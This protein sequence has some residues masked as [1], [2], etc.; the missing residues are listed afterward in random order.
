MNQK[1][2]SDL[3]KIKTELIDQSHF[4][5]DDTDKLFHN[6]YKVTVSYNG[7]KTSF[8]FYDSAHNTDM[9]IEPSKESLLETIVSDYNY[10]DYTTFEEFCGEFGYDKDS[11]KAEK[12][13]KACLKQAEK[14]QKVIPFDVWQKLDDEVNA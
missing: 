4:P 6:V 2:V 5:N 13:F 8:K 1:L 11:R 12:I 7:K 14:I 9:G 3:I 10:T